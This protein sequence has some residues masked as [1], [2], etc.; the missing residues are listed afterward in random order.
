MFKIGDKVVYIGFNNQLFHDLAGRIFTIS[1]QKS[2]DSWKVAEI[3][4]LFTP[5]TRNLVPLEVYNSPL[6][7]ALNEKED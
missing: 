4:Q 7:K 6:W 5:R 3:E 2:T 1:E